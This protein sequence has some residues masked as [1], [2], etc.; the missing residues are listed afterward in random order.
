MKHRILS[1]VL[2]F[3]TAAVQWAHADIR[4]PK[5]F[6]DNMVL[7]RERPI[8]VWGRADRGES[9]TVRFAGAAVSAKADR[10]G[11]WEATLPAMEA[12]AS[13][14]E[15]VV[16]GRSGELRFTNVVVG[17]VWLCSGQSNMEWRMDPT[18]GCEAEIAASDNPNIRLLTVGKRVAF[19][20]QE[21]IA[22]NSWEECGPATSRVF[23]AV[24]YW[25]GKFIQAETGVPVGLINSSW[26]GTDIETWIGWPVMRT[27]PEY[28]AHAG[29]A[30]P[31]A[32][33]GR[34][35]IHSYNAYLAALSDDRGDR[36]RWYDPAVPASDRN[37]QAMDLPQIWENVLG[38]CD[39][40][41]WFRRSVTLPASAAGQEG[42]LH[43]PA[44]D[45]SDVVYLNGTCIGRGSGWNTPRRYRIPAGVLLGGENLI[46]VRVEDTGGEGGIW[47][48]AEELFLET[49]GV[50]YG[51][52]GT[53]RCRPSV[54][55]DMFG[56]GESGDFRKPNSFA[57]LLFN[58]MI[59]PLTSY[60]IKGVIWYQGENNAPRAMRYRE[61]FPAMIRDWRGQWGYD[62][63]FLWVQLASYR[64]V[65]ARPGESQWAELREAQNLTL[66]LPA[67]G[68]AVITDIGE[69]NDIHP[70]NKRDVGYRLSRAAL[71]VAYGR[72]DVAPGGPV[73][74]SMERDGDRLVLSFSATGSLRPADANRYGYLR[75]FSVA[76]PDGRF[77]WAKAYLLD[78]NRVVVFADGVKEPAEVRYGWA[79]NPCDN[80]LTDDSGLLASPFRTDDRPG[81][82]K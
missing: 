39:G 12:D 82:T 23:S 58:G 66:A 31:A 50:R 10:T 80:D 77:V 49:G 75:G 65:K 32:A 13:P 16:S 45:D 68:Q 26:G 3:S 51:L 70:R 18:T 54:T 29:S 15:M 9:V 28:A 46:V 6:G 67:T 17:D 59:A 36:E 21:D 73:Y 38:P 44:V 1:L 2:L 40:R 30:S 20:E 63:P 14:R 22:G 27:M 78:E 76:G 11:R 61:L 25:F 37:W 48:A 47:G 35:T 19:E 79:D 72:S 74:R 55:T 8:R 60:G 52:A 57:S 71:N 53:W 43:L 41:V 24:G 7:Q 34:K 62:F 56:L 81:I 64:P 42:E 4:M 69:A 5:L 33:I